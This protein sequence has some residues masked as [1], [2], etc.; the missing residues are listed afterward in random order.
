MCGWWLDRM[1]P[2]DLAELRELASRWRSH[3]WKPAVS[4]GVVIFAAG[5][6]LVCVQP[7]ASYIQLPISALDGGIGLLGIAGSLASLMLIAH[8]LRASRPWS[9]LFALFLGLT[10]ALRGV[11]ATGD[12]VIARR[13]SPKLLV[14][15]L[16]ATLPPTC[17]VTLRGFNNDVSLLPLFYFRDLTRIVVV[18]DGTQLPQEFSPGFYLFTRDEWTKL[19]VERTAPTD[20]WLVHWT[21]DLLLRPS[22]VPVL[23]V[24]K[25]S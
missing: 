9:A 18:P 10:C 15:R 25:R 5:A 1:L 17:R 3:L 4:C 8:F 19:N 2:H 7:I 20:V 6:V 21:D 13:S 24:E 14:Q 16:L 22:K 11:I 12:I 23:L